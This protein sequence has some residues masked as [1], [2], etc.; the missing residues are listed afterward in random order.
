MLDPF[1]F[2]R[3][4]YATMSLKR[5]IMTDMTL[6]DF[7][8]SEYTLPTFGYNLFVCLLFNSFLLRC[9]RCCDYCQNVLC[10]TFALIS[11]C[12]TMWMNG[13]WVSVCINR[14][15][16]WAGWS[17]RVKWVNFSFT[18]SKSKYNRCTKVPVYWYFLF[19]PI[20]TQTWNVNGSWSLFKYLFIV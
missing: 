14:T 10:I 12:G 13:W 4:C 8:T 11:S 17:V 1:P 7:K 19:R 6:F 16:E 9:W 15:W 18:Q 3:I 20:L 5:K 2:L